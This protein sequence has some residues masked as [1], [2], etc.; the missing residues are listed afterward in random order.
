[1]LKKYKKINEL[2]LLNKFY[3]FYILFNNKLFLQISL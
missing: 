3:K 1:M 2:I